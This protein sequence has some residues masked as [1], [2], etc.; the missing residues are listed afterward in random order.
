MSAKSSWP[1]VTFFET[2]SVSSNKKIENRS[3]IIHHSIIHHHRDTSRRRLPNFHHRLLGGNHDNRSNPAAS[4]QPVTI[5]AACRLLSSLL[6]GSQIK[7]EPSWSHH[8]APLSDLRARLFCSNHP[9]KIEE[10]LQDVFHSITRSL[11]QGI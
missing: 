1:H 11:P 7:A 3:S 4:H 5:D 2:K 6:P 9:K 8:P 10:L